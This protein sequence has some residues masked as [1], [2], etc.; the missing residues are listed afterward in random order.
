MSLTHA[1]RREYKEI[2]QAGNRNSAI[3]IGG[4]KEATIETLANK[5][6]RW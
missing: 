3:E 4:P 6:N 5:I 1:N 2:N